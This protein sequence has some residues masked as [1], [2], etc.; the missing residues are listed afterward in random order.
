MS[1]LPEM[2]IGAPLVPIEPAFRRTSVP[3]TMSAFVALLLAEAMAPPVLPSAI[4]CV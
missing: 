3:V 1:S 4:D 2:R